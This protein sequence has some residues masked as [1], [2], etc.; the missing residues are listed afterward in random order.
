VSSIHSNEV[1]WLRYITCHYDINYI[2]KQ[3]RINYWDKY[4]DWEDYYNHWKVK[5]PGGT[6][7]RLAS[8]LSKGKLINISSIVERRQK[9][10]FRSD[11]VRDVITCGY[12]SSLKIGENTIIIKTTNQGVGVTS[13]GCYFYYTDMIM[14]DFIPGTNIKIFDVITTLVLNP[15]W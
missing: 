14:D 2:T 15:K 12:M 1:F 9:L 10:I 6:Y 5:Y 4:K 13:S 7:F 8:Y 11:N 3:N